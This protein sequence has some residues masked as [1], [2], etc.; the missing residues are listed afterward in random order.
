MSATAAR[1]AAANRTID[2]AHD[3]L[4]LTYEDIAEAV[5]VHRRSVARWRSGDAVPSR[6][7]REA[8]ERLRVLRYLLESVFADEGE[9]QSWLHS[10]VPM[11]RGRTPISLLAEGRVDEVVGV[12]AGLESGAVA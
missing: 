1:I 5:G 7:H 6:R 12:L 8:M 9:A 4:E 3:V 10:S 11:L 2:W